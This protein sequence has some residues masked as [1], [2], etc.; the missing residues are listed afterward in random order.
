MEEALGVFPGFQ[1][2]RRSSWEAGTT[3]VDPKGG[4]A[5]SNGGFKI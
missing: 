3:K 1:G 5:F 2:I 4:Y